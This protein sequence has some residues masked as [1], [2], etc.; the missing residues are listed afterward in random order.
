MGVPVGAPDTEPAMV[1]PGLGNILAPAGMTFMPDAM[2]AAAV[3]VVAIVEVAAIDETQADETSLSLMGVDIR[4]CV[5]PPPGAALIDPLGGPFSGC[6]CCFLE[7]LG[8]RR[9]CGCFVDGGTGNLLDK[10]SGSLG[11]CSGGAT[12]EAVDVET[13]AV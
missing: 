5:V 13:D 3:M 1:P 9:I 6:C 2:A 11:F 8:W 7:T 4:C 12:V 10:S